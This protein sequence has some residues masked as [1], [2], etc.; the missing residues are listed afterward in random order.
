MVYD[1]RQIAIGDNR[2]V[3]AVIAHAREPAHGGPA[4][5]VSTAVILAHGAG[6][7]M[8][9]PLLSAVHTGL[10]TRGYVAVKFNFPYTER[11]GRAP[12]PAPVLEA[13]YARVIEAI[14]H[15][16]QIAPRRLVIG[17]KSLGGRMASHLAAKGED[18]AGLIF[19]GYPLHPAGKPERL[20]VAHLDQIQSPMLF[21]AGTRDP[22]CNLDLL[23]ETIR[24]LPARVTLHVIEGADHSF[25]L[26]KRL[27]RDPSAVWEEII[28]TS[29]DWLA[30]RPG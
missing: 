18:V 19:L 23:T 11:G 22:L 9:A 25:K 1:R 20:R 3:S 6:S 16:P 30:R 12:D 5:E 2:T 7:D 17:G 14:R 13:C 24:R 15:D 27:G 21:F 8:N 28:A 10:A 4:P 29:A 26:P